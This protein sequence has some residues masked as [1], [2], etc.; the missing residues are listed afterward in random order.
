[1]A[2]GRRSI[3]SENPFL[4]LS[5]PGYD[6]GYFSFAGAQA[7]VTIKVATWSIAIHSVDTKNTLPRVPVGFIASELQRI[8]DG[9][10]I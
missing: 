8:P 1:M 4:P 2:F 10:V 3:V 9:A 7:D 5:G 6:L